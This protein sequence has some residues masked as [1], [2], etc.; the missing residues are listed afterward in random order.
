MNFSANTVYSLDRLVRFSTFISLSKRW[1]WVF[2]GVASGF[3]ALTFVL[4][5]ALF[6]F[7]A[8]VLWSFLG[9][10]FI[11]ALYAFLCFGLPRITYKKSPALDAKIHYEFFNDCYAV[12]SVL[13]NGNEKS[14]L[15][16]QTVKKVMRYKNDVYLFIGPNQAYIID[17]DG[18]E[19]GSA[20]ALVSFIEAKIEARKFLEKREK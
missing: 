1:V 18:F 4:Y 15:N 12:T 9:I 13:A 6:G 10:I 5:F 7:D 20:D 19:L 8:T 3:V 17:T 14:E 2:L 11:D 16:Y